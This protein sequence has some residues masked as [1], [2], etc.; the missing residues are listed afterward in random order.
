MPGYGGG[1]VKAAAAAD[2]MDLAE[3]RHSSAKYSP[4]LHAADERA[5][6]KRETEERG[7]AAARYEHDKRYSSW[8][9]GGGDV[10]VKVEERKR[11]GGARDEDWYHR[12]EQRVKNDTERL[13]R[14]YERINSQPTLGAHD[15]SVRDIII[16][17]ISVNHCDRQA[18]QHNDNVVHRVIMVA[19]C[20]GADH[21]IFALW[22]LSSFFFLFFLA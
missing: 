9:G 13:P 19:L 16:I 11:V 14:G 7:A 6:M 4:R 8:R 15:R 12:D 21:Y 1:S 22:F 10:D 20:N 17:I 5:R 3:S 2:K 18:Q